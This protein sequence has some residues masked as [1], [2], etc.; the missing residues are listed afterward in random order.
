MSTELSFITINALLHIF[1]PENPDVTMTTYAGL[2]SWGITGVSGYLAR[3]AEAYKAFF[4]LGIS[5]NRTYI[6][7]AGAKN[8]AYLIIVI[9]I[10]LTYKKFV[11]LRKISKGSAWQF[12]IAVAALPLCVNLTIIMTDPKSVS[13]LHLLTYIM[14]VVFV[15]QRAE[16]I[17]GLTGKD[18]FR[19]TIIVL[20]MLSS[21]IMAKH[22]NTCYMKLEV[23]QTQAISYFTT[24]ITR[25]KSVEGYKDELPVAYINAYDKQD[26][27]IPYIK[28]YDNLTAVYPYR[29]ADLLSTPEK[30]AL[31]KSGY[32]DHGYLINNYAWIYFMKIWCGYEP[33]LVEKG[34]RLKL[35]TLPEIR[36]M[37]QYPDDGSI[38]I[39][40][41]VV[42]V[43]F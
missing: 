22:D 7:T 10:Y 43:K 38:K 20:L 40:D 5:P 13:P 14:W 33:Q 25:I 11:Y 9:A 19:K 12:L 15:L 41:G 32:S 35:E 2:S 18:F 8:I 23:C 21:F 24:L 4:V 28:E 37:P 42:V 17:P 26:E 34:D 39:I 29:I 30:T 31:M 6:F 36:N 3:I 27:T 16:A 1:K